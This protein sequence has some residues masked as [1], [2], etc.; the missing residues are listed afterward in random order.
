ME[1]VI[2]R[3][4]PGVRLPIPMPSME[5]D[6]LRLS[7]I[8]RKCSASSPTFC[9]FTRPFR[10]LSRISSTG[11]AEGAKVREWLFWQFVF[12]PVNLQPVGRWSPHPQCPKRWERFQLDCTP[13]VRHGIKGQITLNGGE[14]WICPD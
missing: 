7:V 6:W 10:L 1:F 13:K 5:S 4:T 9:F 2:V 11:R 3:V 12:F 14:Q 8:R